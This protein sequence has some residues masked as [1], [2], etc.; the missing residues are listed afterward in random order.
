MIQAIEVFKDLPVD[1]I[2][3]DASVIEWTTAKSMQDA[4][5]KYL[6][7]NNYFCAFLEPEK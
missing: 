4:A 5:K 3:D 1:A 2:S 7:T 6:N